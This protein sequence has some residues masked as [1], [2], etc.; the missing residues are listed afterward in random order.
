MDRVTLRQVFW[1]RN[2]LMFS[3]RA[4]IAAMVRIIRRGVMPTRRIVT[5]Y[6]LLCIRTLSRHSVALSRCG[7]TSSCQPSR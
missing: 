2:F 6:T 1:D 3:Q 7:F 5:I 4:A